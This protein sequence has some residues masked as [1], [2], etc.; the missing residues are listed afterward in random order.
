MGTKHRRTRLWVDASLQGALLLRL[1][2]YLLAFAFVVWHLAFVFAVMSGLARSRPQAGASDLYLEYLGMQWP[3]LYA[4]VLAA[5]VLLYDLLRFSNRIAG[6]L[7]RCRRVMEEMAAGKVV[8][9]FT[10][11]QH[12][13][14][15]PFFHSFNTLIETC[16][17]RVGESANG[18]PA[19]AE[20]IP[21]GE[22][23]ASRSCG[24]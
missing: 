5:P 18:T 2:C 4:I 24:V 6:P 19:G 3:L 1:V 21:A 10:P 12:D 9:K 13:F 7:F 20:S 11:R 22:C 16:N 14:L 15:G 23:E 8:D 17:A